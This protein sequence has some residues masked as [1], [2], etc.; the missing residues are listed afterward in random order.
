MTRVNGYSTNYWQ[1]KEE[2]PV[3]E[4]RPGMASKPGDLNYGPGEPALAE[5]HLEPE[6]KDV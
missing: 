4:D 2:R 6:R 3:C 1:E 5:I